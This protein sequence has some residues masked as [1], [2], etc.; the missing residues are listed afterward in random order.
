MGMER[1]MEGSGKVQMQEIAS[2]AL[3]DC[4]VCCDVSV[5]R[6]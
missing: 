1:A 4:V 3:C 5:V 2:V 6:G